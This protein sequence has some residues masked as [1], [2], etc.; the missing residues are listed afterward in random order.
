MTS[1]EMREADEEIVKI[2]EAKQ[3]LLGVTLFVSFVISIV[4]DLI[5]GTFTNSILIHVI[6]VVCGLV[7]LFLY[8]FIGSITAELLE[9]LAELSEE[10]EHGFNK[11]TKILYAAFFPAAFPVFAS[12]YIGMTFINGLFH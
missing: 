9:F 4:I 3:I 6:S 8:P 7:S 5:L 2:K 11:S 1:V 12:Y 10:H